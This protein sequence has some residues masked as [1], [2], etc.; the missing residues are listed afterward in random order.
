MTPPIPLGILASIRAAAAAVS[1]GGSFTYLGSGQSSNG[2]SATQTIAA[3]PFGTP[4]AGRV[5]VAAIGARV[6]SGRS[7]VSVTIGGVSATVDRVTT[8]WP[9]AFI[10]RAIVPTGTSGDVVVT[11]SGAE[12]SP[13]NAFVYVA[14]GN[15][16]LDLMPIVT[17]SASGAHYSGSTAASSTSVSNAAGACLIAVANTSSTVA[18]TFIWGGGLVEDHFLSVANSSGS[19]THAN[20]IAVGPTTVAATSTEALYQGLAAVAYDISVTA[21]TVFPTATLYPSASTFPGFN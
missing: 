20:G 3:L 4:A 17:V 19:A 7:L 21:A 13:V 14:E 6:A 15:T 18:R 5:I 16:P 1:G 10:A 2:S 12:T 8:T 9:A 11:Y